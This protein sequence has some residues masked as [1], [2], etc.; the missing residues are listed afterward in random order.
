M[1]PDRRA[2]LI[3][4]YVEALDDNDPDRMR[5][6]VTA[7]FV[8][9]YVDR[10]LRGRSEVIRFLRD[11]RA[12]DS[13]HELECILHGEDRSIAQGSATGTG[14]DGTF[15]SEMC[16]VFRFDAEEDRLRQVKIFARF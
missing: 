9:Y 5:G 8:Y 1:D 11:E 14:P 15:E 16:D 12:V 6:I 2:D 3:H 13:D 4:A 10:V 7:D